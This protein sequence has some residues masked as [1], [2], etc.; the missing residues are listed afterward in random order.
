MEANMVTS[1]HNDERFSNRFTDCKSPIKLTQ[2][3]HG[4]LLSHPVHFLKSTNDQ[5]LFHATQQVICLCNKSNIYLHS[6][7]F[8]HAI[9]GKID[10]FDLFTGELALKDFHEL[11]NVWAERK[12]IRVMPFE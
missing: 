5:I 7:D 3:Y 6:S 2:I 8:T 9:A 1:K 11:R 10:A 4:L 12:H